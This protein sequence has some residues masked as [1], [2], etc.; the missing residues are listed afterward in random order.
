[1]RKGIDIIKQV[2]EK[3]GK[4]AD[5]GDYIDD[6]KKSDAPQFKGKSDKKKEKMAV[7]AYLDSKEE[8][9]EEKRY[10]YDGKNPI[11]MSKKEF[12]KVKNDDKLY[13]NGKPSIAAFN[14]KSKV[15][16]FAPVVFEEVNEKYTSVGSGKLTPAQ[17]KFADV[18]Q[19]LDKD[20]QAKKSAY[21][22][23]PEKG[24][25]VDFGMG[26][27]SGMAVYRSKKDAEEFA[28]RQ[29]RLGSK[30]KITPGKYDQF[31]DPREEVEIKEMD[32]LITTKDDR[33]SVEVQK[34]LQ[35]LASGKY[36]SELRGVEVIE[37][38]KILQMFDMSANVV[39]F[40]VKKELEKKFRNN[41]KVVMEEV[42]EEKRQLKDPKK[43]A[44]VM[45]VKDSGSI[46]VIDKKDLEK[47]LSKGYIQVED[48]AL[49]ELKA[50]DPMSKSYLYLT[51]PITVQYT[52]IKNPIGFAKT[53]KNTKTGKALKTVYPIKMGS[54]EYVLKGTGQQH[55]EFLKT[56]NNKG[57]MPKNKI[58]KEE[59]D[60][61][62]ARLPSFKDLVKYKYGD[63]HAGAIHFSK[64]GGKEYHWNYLDR[65]KRGQYSIS[66]KK[67]GEI[68]VSR[69]GADSKINKVI[70]DEVDIQESSFHLHCIQES[71]HTDVASM[72][73]QV[74][75]ATDALQKMNTELGKLSDEED[76][77][78]WWTNKVATAVSKLDGMADYIDAK[79]N[80][81]KT[82]KEEYKSLNESA[83]GCLQTAM[84]DNNKSL[85]KESKMGELF[86]DMQMD[87]QEMDERDFVKMYTKKGFQAAELKSLY[88]E[89]SEEV[90]KEVVDNSLMSQ[91]T[92]VISQTAIQEKI[93]PAD[94]DNIA[95]ADDRKAAD[96]NIIIQLRRAQDM[97]GKADVTFKDNPKKKEKLDIRVI[98][99]VLDMFD[100]LRPND[101]AKMQT[102][103]GKSYR[104][105]LKTVQRGR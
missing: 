81:G 17:K 27:D 90:V 64:I 98:N 49:S 26:K 105:L 65:N 101:K 58:V 82:M 1:M 70:N 12:S 48:N 41:I 56:L 32:L 89:F 52:Y 66:T 4:S 97:K 96:K 37:P 57:I 30:T 78:T 25:K 9:K 54:G 86:L 8:V 62:E 45:K 33:T 10:E 21:L 80:M 11:K 19:K 47:Y 36:K 24:F 46:M 35:S 20:R 29:K 76:L 44:M 63:D 99:K 40:K 6:F 68:R 85:K 77:P 71:G 59:T 95:T 3:L 75:I 50:N 91:A 83:I 92:R 5:A 67:T 34:F 100:S 53:L 31:D 14:K 73:T 42:K 38:K 88:K 7:A 55:I 15:D 51:K 16:V 61:Q 84:I 103:I 74:Q 93:D 43:E 104:D 28:K 79:Q 102:T 39:P 13:S 60:I 72:K 94:M 87:A 69:A 22:K 2:K 23:T 18:L